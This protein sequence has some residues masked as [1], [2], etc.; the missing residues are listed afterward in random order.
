[1]FVFCIFCIATVEDYH[2]TLE[3]FETLSESQGGDKMTLNMD[4]FDEVFSLIC[5]DPSEHF[6]LFDTW[7]I[8]KVDALEVLAV[9]IVFSKSTMEDKI[10][11]LFNLYVS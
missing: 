9:T 2:T 11:L 1:L 5:Q 6:K 10:S 7:Q 4:E 8:G 3:N